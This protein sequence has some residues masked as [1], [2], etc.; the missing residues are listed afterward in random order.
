MNDKPLSCT[1]KPAVGLTAESGKTGQFGCKIIDISFPS[2]VNPELSEDN[3]GIGEIHFQNYYVAYVSVKAKIK[4]TED[5]PREGTNDQGWRLVVR[6]FKLMPDPHSETGAQDVFRLT[7]KHFFC[8]ITNIV[9]LRIILQQPSPIWKEF[10]LEDIKLFRKQNGGRV[11]P[12][13]SWV[14]DDD[15]TKIGK[16]ELEGVPDLDSLSANLQQLWALA[17]EAASNQTEE[18]LGRYERPAIPKKMEMKRPL[19]CAYE[20]SILMSPFKTS[21][22]Q[23]PL[24]QWQ[25]HNIIKRSVLHLCFLIIYLEF[26]T[27][28]GISVILQGS[29]QPNILLLVR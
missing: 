19:N 17:E 3:V 8:N 29:L 11:P 23:R 20:P 14:M 16:K 26:S 15:K 25:S 1:I 28:I 10:K 12:L 7:G 2:I 13:P 5:T 6:R 21:C 4:L 27:G 24:N 18:S 22:A 9:S